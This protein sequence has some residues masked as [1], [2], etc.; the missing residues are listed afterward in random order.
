MRIHTNK[1]D[2]VHRAIW[3]ATRKMVNVRVDID[4]HGSRSRAGAVEMKLTGNSPR[5]PNSG[6]WGADTYEY[7]ATW[8]EWG[9]VLAAVYAADPDAICGSVK[10]PVYAGADD[11]HRQTGERFAGIQKGE[12]PNS[13]PADTHALHRWEPVRAGAQQCRKCTATRYAPLRG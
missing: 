9:M 6:R 13:L 5:H 11:F 2:E 4:E 1:V 3:R 8:D 7:A 12:A 10:H